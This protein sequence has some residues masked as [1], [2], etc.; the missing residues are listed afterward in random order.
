MC[1]YIGSGMSLKL[2]LG[3]G[4]RPYEDYLGVDIG[5]SSSRVV[6]KDVLDYLESLPDASVSHIYSRH[7]LEHVSGDGLVKIFK[8]ID[9]VLLPGGLIHFIVPHYSNPFFYSDPTHKTFFGIHTFSYYCE[10]SC[11][12]RGVP[13]YASIKGWSLDKVNVNFVSMFNWKFFGKKI[14]FFCIALNRLVNSHNYLLEIYERYFANIFS[15]Y[16]I[17]FRITK[18]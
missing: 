2:D 14:P 4:A 12:K 9:R 17:D 6:Q 16:E 15:I 8:E 13:K 7:Y 18:K 10:K 1:P 11:L 3:S 5:F